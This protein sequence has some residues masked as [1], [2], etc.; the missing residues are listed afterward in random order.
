M[1]RGKRWDLSVSHKDK[2]GNW[3]SS[4][5]GVI[6]EGDKGQLQIRIDPGVSV[7]TPEG[8]LLTG[9]IPKPRDGQGSGRPQSGGG[10]GGGGDSY[11]DG[12][13]GIPF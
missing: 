5:V 10:G 7:S 13:S 4:R 11:D 9:W 1:S 12:D 3:R 2:Q 6:F 8:V